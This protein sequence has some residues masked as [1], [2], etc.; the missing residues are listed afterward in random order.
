MLERFHFCDVGGPYLFVTAFSF[1]HMEGAERA[2]LASL[3]LFEAR[4]VIERLHMTDPQLFRRVYAAVLGSDYGFSH[5][6]FRIPGTVIGTNTRVQELVAALGIEMGAQGAPLSFARLY[7]LRAAQGQAPASHESQ[8]SRQADDAIAKLGPRSVSHRG[9]DYIVARV[10]DAVRVSQRERYDTLSEREALVILKEMAK[11]PL[12]APL[13]QKGLAELVELVVARKVAVLVLRERRVFVLPAQQEAAV[14]ASRLRKAVP[15]WVEV[16]AVDRHKQPVA[17]VRL[18]VVL[19]SGLTT[20]MTTN[21]EGLARQY[22]GRNGRY[23]RTRSTERRLA[24][25]IRSAKNQQARQVDDARRAKRRR[26][27]KRGQAPWPAELEDDL[28]SP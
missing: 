28:G 6:R 24:T 7:V 17:G 27:R 9:R 26:A 20:S 21:A 23:P 11:D 19:V 22:A 18:Q 2:R 15:H 14:P 12:L 16:E 3:S 5:S 4:A 1:R 25:R 13:Q 8:A 10:E